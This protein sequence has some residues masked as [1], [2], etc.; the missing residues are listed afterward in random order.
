MPFAT[1]AGSLANV[2]IIYVHG[3]CKHSA[4]FSNDW[5]AA[6]TQYLPSL[7]A[8]NH[9]EVVWSDIIEPGTA[10]P[11][12]VREGRRATEALELARPR[13][14]AGGK[15]ALSAQIKDVLADRASRQFLSAVLP[16]TAPGAAGSA[17]LGPNKEI[18]G[19]QV[20]FNIPG[21]ECID[22]FVDYLLDNALRTQV[23]DRFHG[24]V[25]PLLLQSGAIVHVIGHSWGTVV[26]YEALRG[27]DQAAELADGSI[28]TLFTVGS[29]LAI[30]PVKR[31]LLASAIDGSRPRLV[32][33]WV[34][35]NAHFDIVG[36]HLQNNPFQVDDE[37]LELPAVGCSTLIPNPVCA[38]SSYFQA[39]NQT[40]N[41]D[42]FARYIQE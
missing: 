24:V 17:V 7:L 36:G 3:I 10:Q 8:S 15:S 9:H 39:A 2:H 37:Y 29:A 42:I 14:L 1:E 28:H 5:W 41:R 34:N 27:L 13:P 31:M 32:R 40:V 12:M 25:G 35:L 38:H 21:V 19:P 4:G 26:A 23:I 22:D 30:P 33:T 20:L 18:I 6:L 11:D 16:T